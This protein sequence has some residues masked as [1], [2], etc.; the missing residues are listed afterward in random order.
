MRD[1]DIHIGDMVRVRQWKDM[2]SEGWAN[3]LGNIS[4][5]GRYIQFAKGMKYLCGEI[6]TVKDITDHHF[7]GET[8][9]RSS[10]NIEH[11]KEHGGIWYLTA[12]MIEPYDDI[13]YDVAGDE[14]IKL[15]LA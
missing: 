4:F 8:I 9:Y 2:E 6:F 10:E 14:D 3:H 1:E 7:A 12:P 15:L 13:E 11:K 5:S